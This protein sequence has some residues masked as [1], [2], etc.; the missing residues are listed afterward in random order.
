MFENLNN[1][2]EFQQKIRN[3][4][5]ITK[6]NSRTEKQKAEMKNSIV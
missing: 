3:Y 1:R 6:E 4:T 2:K 5:K